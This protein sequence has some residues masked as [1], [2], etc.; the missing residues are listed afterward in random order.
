MTQAKY[1]RIAQDLL[2][3]I[4]SG[5]L[6]PG[7]QLTTELELGRK[8]SASRN[9]IRSAVQWLVLR[10]LVEA[11]PGQGTFVAQRTQPFVTTMSIDVWTGLS[12]LEGSGWLAEVSA[13]GVH[14]MATAPRV[15][16]RSAPRHIA[17]RLHVTEGTQILIRRQER[18]TDQAPYSLQTTAYPMELVTRG[19]TRL[20]TAE[21]IPEGAV[22]YVSQELGLKEVGHRDRLLV[23]LPKEE[24][25][26]FF[27]LP[28]DGRVCVVSVVRTGYRD[29]DDGPV[30]LR[31]TYTVF[32]AD[33]QQLVIDSGEVPKDPPGPAEG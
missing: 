30:P 33:R 16:V 21:D 1:R 6:R 31:V 13:R 17:D 5:A 8:Y 24:E 20:L 23:R 2:E 25:A 7:E 27:R 29:G 18:Y 10:G 12:G 4:Q 32:P 19:A 28:D 14:A 22:A 3:Q 11:K 9:T 15:E 26:R